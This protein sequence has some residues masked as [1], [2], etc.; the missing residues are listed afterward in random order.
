M[1]AILLTVLIAFVVLLTGGAAP[2]LARTVGSETGL[3]IPRYVTL[4]TAEANMRSGPGVRYPV[5]WVFLR[6]NLP[7]EVIAEF[8]NWRKIRGHENT[9]G[10]VHQSMLSGRRTVVVIG[11]VRTL[12]REPTDSTPAVARMEAGVIGWLEE[13]RPQWCEV[14][15]SGIT[16]WVHRAHIWGV[17]ETEAL[18]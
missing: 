9:E 2:V 17:R 7:V 4:R 6:R 13:C 11:P 10:W 1:P 16:G 8:D 5:Q 18:E 15:V 3:P 12:R 14:E